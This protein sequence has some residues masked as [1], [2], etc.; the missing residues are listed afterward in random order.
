MRPIFL[1]LKLDMTCQI[2]NGEEHN[3]KNIFLEQLKFEKSV[4]VRL[5]CQKVVKTIFRLV[6]IY[7][8]DINAGKESLLF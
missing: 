4:L 5:F 1:L 2:Q 7:F 8:L 3:K 6:G